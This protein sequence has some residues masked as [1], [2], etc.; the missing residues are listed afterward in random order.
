MFFSSS[1]APSG[2]YPGLT[3]RWDN[4]STL[5]AGNSLNI[6]PVGLHKPGGETCRCYD[7]DIITPHLF[8]KQSAGDRLH[9]WGGSRVHRPTCCYLINQFSERP[10]PCRGSNICGVIT[11]CTVHRITITVLLLLFW[12]NYRKRSKSIVSLAYYTIPFDYTRNP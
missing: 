4:I 1:R 2:L 12:L 5:Y 9:R 6:V 7:E 3:L 8:P 10:L 11:I